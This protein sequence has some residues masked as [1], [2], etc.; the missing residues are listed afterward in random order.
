VEHHGGLEAEAGAGDEVAAEAFV[1]ESQS[2]T[3]AEWREIDGEDL[4]IEI[5][6]GMEF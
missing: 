6:F 5:G 4:R 2:F 1:E 3:G